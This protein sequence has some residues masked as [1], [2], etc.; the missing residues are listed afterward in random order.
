VTL[1]DSV[2]DQKPNS[3][4]VKDPNLR[5]VFYCF[6]KLTQQVKLVALGVMHE[7]LLFTL[8]SEFAT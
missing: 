7:V 2:C 3:Y 1:A 4:Q 8:S 6:F 5:H